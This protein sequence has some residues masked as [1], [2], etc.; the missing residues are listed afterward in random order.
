LDRAV[1]K[2]Q[3]RAALD[4]GS[5]QALVQP[6][7]CGLLD[8]PALTLGIE[9]EKDLRYGRPVALDEETMG[10]GEKANGTEARGYAE[11]GSL[12]GIIRWDA[13]ASMWRPR[14]VFSLGASKHESE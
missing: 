8:L 13:E 11:D 14:K 6:M 1:G 7:D 4:D 9:D 12:I 3:L 5:W 10:L 2:E